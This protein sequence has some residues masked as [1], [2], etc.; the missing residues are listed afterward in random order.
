MFESALD[1]RESVT[2]T[3]ALAQFRYVYPSLLEGSGK[4]VPSH[5]EGIYTVM[6]DCKEHLAATISVTDKAQ[7]QLVRQ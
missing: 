3:F 6:L 7:G 4:I 2:G 5:D 1:S